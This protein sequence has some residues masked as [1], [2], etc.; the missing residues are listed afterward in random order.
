MNLKATE[1]SLTYI[2]RLE[3]KKEKNHTETIAQK[4]TRGTGTEEVA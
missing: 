4:D 2:T 1:L 3:G